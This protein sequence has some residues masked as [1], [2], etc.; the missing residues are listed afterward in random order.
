MTV[1]TF[2]PFTVLPLAALLLAACATPYDVTK[3]SRHDNQ[4]TKR[5][6]H[7]NR[8]GCGS[9]YGMVFSD[10]EW[11]E[12]G[13]FFAGTTDAA[14]E[15]RRIAAAITRFE[16]IAGPKDGTDK[17]VGGSGL[18]DPGVGQLDCYAEAANTTVA[19]QMMQASGFLKFHTVGE[20][21]MRGLPYG[22]LGIEHATATIVETATGER[23]AVD[24]WFFDNG[25]P[26]FVV[27]FEEWRGGWSPEG[28]AS[29]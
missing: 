6:T 28:G 15:R 5:F 27:D 12:I 21:R 3:T 4:P 23:F 7:C 17:D 11:A 8:F 24:T 10:A 26:T 16:Q 14:D 29:I 19:L 25:G 9:M 13:A 18:I 20:A 1:R 22:T 2:R